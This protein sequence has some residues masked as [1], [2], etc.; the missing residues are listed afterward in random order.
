VPPVDDVD[1]PAVLAA[2]RQLDI[3]VAFEHDIFHP[4]QS[5]LKYVAIHYAK[6]RRSVTGIGLGESS[7]GL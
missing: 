2:V 1:D 6:V 5:P 7:V 4:P 3:F